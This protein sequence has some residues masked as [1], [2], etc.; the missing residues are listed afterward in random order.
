MAAEDLIDRLFQDG[1]IER[2]FQAHRDGD[3]IE[4]AAASELFQKPESLLPG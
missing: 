1:G 3:V 4:R 2:A